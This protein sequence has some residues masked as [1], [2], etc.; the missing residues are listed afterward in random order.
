[1]EEGKSLK[2]ELQEIKELVKDTERKPKKQRV[3]NCPF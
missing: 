3:K 1:M 2:E